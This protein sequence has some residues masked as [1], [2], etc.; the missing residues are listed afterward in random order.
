M[1]NSTS[2]TGPWLG[3]LIRLR[4]SEPDDWPSHQ[5][6][7]DDWEM[8]TNL[9][10]PVFPKSTEAARAFARDSAT[11]EIVGDSIHLEIESLD[12]TEHVGSIGTNNVDPRNGTFSYGIG[13][14]ALHRGHGYAADAVIVLV[15]FFFQE[16]RYQKC[17]AEVSSWNDASVRLQ[18]SLGF[19]QEGRI[20]RMVF[21]DGNYHDSLIFGIT[22]EEW[23]AKHSRSPDS[24]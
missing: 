16:L 14:D 15:N 1:A 8:M 17:N 5:R 20:R 10:G 21:T 9:Q 12:T 19:T 13:I 4:R 6:W 23:L 7:N 2:L 11:S 22:R 3:K 24:S 18:Q